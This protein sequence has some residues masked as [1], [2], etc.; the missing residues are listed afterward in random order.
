MERVLVFL[1]HFNAVRV[2]SIV[3]FVRRVVV[4]ICCSILTVFQLHHVHPPTSS[5]PPIISVFHATF[6]VP[7]VLRGLLN[8]HHV[9]EDHYM[10]IVAG[11]NAIL[12]STLH[13]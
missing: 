10:R 12:A 7:L 5:I 8:A 9:S 11:T 6:L 2:I 3:Q 4:D 13:M 1:A